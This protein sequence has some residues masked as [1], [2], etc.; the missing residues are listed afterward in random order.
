MRPKR[1]WGG[2]PFADQSAR[3]MATHVRNAVT[4]QLSRSREIG[5]TP[6]DADPTDN[7]HAN[8]IGTCRKEEVYIVYAALENILLTL[9]C[10]FNVLRERVFPLAKPVWSTGT[11]QVEVEVVATGDIYHVDIDI[12]KR[13]GIIQG[14]HIFLI[15]A[16]IRHSNLDL[17]SFSIEIEGANSESPLDSQDVAPKILNARSPSALRTAQTATPVGA[18][19]PSASSEPEAAPEAS[20]S[21]VQVAFADL[22]IADEGDDDDEEDGSGEE[23]SDTDPTDFGT[24]NIQAEREEYEAKEKGKEQLGL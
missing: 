18:P 21:T 11:E 13:M 16:Y 17:S 1:D 20:T 12:A 7:H 3:I 19:S 9:C 6:L 5:L 10:T 22:A 2:V 15:R 14:K 4:R 24:A 8:N 23:Y